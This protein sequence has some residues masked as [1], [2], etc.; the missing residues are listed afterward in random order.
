MILSDIL[1][2]AVISGVSETSL[3]ERDVA[4]EQ[5]RR[6]IESVVLVVGLGLAR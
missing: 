6:P 2:Y 4:I 5:P 3:M 1:Y